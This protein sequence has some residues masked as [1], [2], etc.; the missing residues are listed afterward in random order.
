MNPSLRHNI[1]LKPVNNPNNYM[2]KKI[3]LV[4]SGISFIDEAWGGFYRGGTYLL[5]GPRKSG[6]TLIGLQFTKECVEQQE[7]CLYFT[8]MRPKDLMINASSIDFDL[9]SCMSQN[10]VVVV[11]VNSPGDA[12][13]YSEPDE[14]LSEYLRDIVPVIEQYQPSK[15]VFDEMTPFTGFNNI[16]KLKEAFIKTC[17]EIEEYGITSL[18]IIGEPATPSAGTIVYSLSENSTGTIHLQKKENSEEGMFAGGII[19][20]TPNVGHTEGQFSA[21]YH[22]AP[23][24]G[25]VTEIS[26]Q[27]SVQI[28][29][30]ETKEE[31][32]Y[33][34]LSQ[35]ETKTE[36]YSFTNYYD[37]D[38]FYLILNNQIAFYKST[39]Q[40]FV[41]VSLMLDE[42]AVNQGLL[43]LSQLKNAVR[44][45][46]SKKDKICVIDNRVVVLITKEDRK[47]VNNLVA[48]IKENLPG[49]D[50][51]Y[52][53]R[54]AQYIS[55]CTLQVDDSIN[56][57]DD[58]LK[59]TS[60]KEIS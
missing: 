29:T 54:V 56:N 51:E 27:P 25:F 16:E 20:I 55:V 58:L 47:N 30:S 34:S 60:V 21:S 53:S 2:R 12:S 39:G 15:L 19:T 26:K 23:N 32:L 3:Q 11:R 33:K 59:Q 31:S 9:Q 5:V 4:P 7:V 10:K 46:T 1:W 14:Y 42:S 36:N 35:I 13:S 44:L 43:T 6:R 41:V 22:I 38:D 40:T 50:R 28:G 48:R 24:K 18:F 8:T 49:T 57:A 45:S 17:E 52:L 37:Y